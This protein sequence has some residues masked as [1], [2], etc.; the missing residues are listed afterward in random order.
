MHQFGDRLVRAL[1]CHL[2]QTFFP[3]F[4]SFSP[5]NLTFRV[6][7]FGHHERVRSGDINVGRCDGQNQTSLTLNI[8]EDHV[9]DLD[10][11]ICRLIPNWD[12]GQ[13]R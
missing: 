12:L 10:C 13:T 4:P 1:F 11:Y 5:K 8:T 2:F 6:S 3:V 7:L 9:S